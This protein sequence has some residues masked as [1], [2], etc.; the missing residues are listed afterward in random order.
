MTSVLDIDKTKETWA[1]PR[2]RFTSSSLREACLVHIY[3]S[4]PTMGRRYP[5]TESEIVVG[6]GE[7]CTICIPDNSVSR[8]HAQ[9]Q[10]TADGF[11]VTDLGSKNGTF[12]NDRQLDAPTQLSD[13]DNLRIGNFLY[14]Y[15]A[16][17][18]VE[19]DYHEEI[20]RLT[21]RDG[22]TRAHN[23]RALT[24]FL[25]RE[26]VRAERHR[27]P[28]AVLMIDIDHFKSIND[29]RGHL[30]GDLVLR[31]LADCLSDRIRAE[32]LF[33]RYGGEEFCMVLVETTL[34]EAR[35][36]GERVRRAVSDLEI[37]FEGAVIRITVS[38]GVAGT[39][40]ETHVLSR[41]LIQRADEKLYEAKRSGRN[42]VLAEDLPVEVPVVTGLT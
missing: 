34:E 42:R 18:S 14:R 15:L 16:G 3:P 17:G 37:P 20:Y 10:A 11:R 4:G 13:G 8:M 7:N 19:A 33:A 5:L 26:L 9:L 1:A 22:L 27:R 29:T 40:G 31:K 6:R 39:T 28:L 25:E 23:R 30:C 21:I 35:E 38:I 12:V 41:D 24:E 32:D 36:I 2:E